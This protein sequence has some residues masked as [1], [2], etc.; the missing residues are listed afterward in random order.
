[1]PLS[2][3]PADPN[4]PKGMAWA[5]AAGFP[6]PRGGTFSNQQ[7]VLIQG[8]DSWSEQLWDLGFRWHPELQTKWVKGGSQFAVGTLVDEKPPE[9]ATFEQECDEVLEMIAESNPGFVDEIR[10]IRDSGTEAER[11]VAVSELQKNVA[12]MM[13]LAQFVQQQ[14]GGQG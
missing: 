9:A 14:G 8:W 4:H 12:D 1:M 11:T 13:R 3:H 2:H 7:L 5:M 6:D 10:R